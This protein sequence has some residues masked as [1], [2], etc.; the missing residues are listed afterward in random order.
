MFPNSNHLQLETRGGPIVYE[1]GPG[2][3]GYGSWNEDLPLGDLEEENDEHVTT[4]STERDLFGTEVFDDATVTQVLNG[5]FERARGGLNFVITRAIRQNMTLRHFKDSAFAEADDLMEQGVY[6]ELKYSG[7]FDARELT[8]VG[9]VSLLDRIM[10]KNSGL[11]S[12]VEKMLVH[13]YLQYI[14]AM[15]Q[16][17]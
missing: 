7:I 5:A 9:F 16:I 12:Q 14:E 17:F 13:A 11:S 3:Y 4:M 2:P 8:P 10:A 6:Q 15:E 1:K